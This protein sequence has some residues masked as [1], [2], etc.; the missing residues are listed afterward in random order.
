MQIKYVEVKYLF[1]LKKLFIQASKQS[2]D[3]GKSR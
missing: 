2:E 1:E 3:T